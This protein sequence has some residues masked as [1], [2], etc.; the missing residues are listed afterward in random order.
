LRA[1]EHSQ[2]YKVG[3]FI[4]E[5]GLIT[6][7]NVKRG[8]P[9]KADKDVAQAKPRSGGRARSAAPPSDPMETTGSG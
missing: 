8:D 1:Y 9:F 2:Q 7:L 6:K 3:K 4:L 5:K